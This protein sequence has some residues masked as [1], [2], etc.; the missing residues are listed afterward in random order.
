M[1]TSSSHRRDTFCW[2]YTRNGQYT[3][4]KEWDVVLLEDY[5]HPEDIPLIRTGRGKESAG[6][7]YH[8][9]SSLCLEAESAKED[10][11]S[12]LAID[13]GSGGSD[14]EFSKAEYEV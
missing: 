9:A 12:Y 2:S 11:S 5:V 4:T 6:T 13:N 7:K 1:A 8:Q 3:E 14:E 10:V